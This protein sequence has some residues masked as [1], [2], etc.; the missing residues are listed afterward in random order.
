MR[1]TLT[2]PVWSVS[3]DRFAYTGR[4]RPRA[5]LGLM[6]PA[7]VGGPSWRTTRHSPRADGGYGTKTP[8]E[9]PQA[10]EQRVDEVLVEL[11]GPAPQLQNPTRAFGSG[12]GPRASSLSSCDTAHHRT[13]QTRFSNEIAKLR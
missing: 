8:G 4:A 7:S 12:P 11:E 1:P 10:L 13:A 9:A 5:R 3:P 2:E 6:L